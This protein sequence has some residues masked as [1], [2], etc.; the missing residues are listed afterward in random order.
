MLNT[1]L[2]RKTSLI[3]LGILALTVALMLSYVA[4]KAD[5]TRSA[6]RQIDQ[7]RALFNQTSSELAGSAAAIDPS[8]TPSPAVLGADVTPTPT[9]TPDPTPTPSDTPQASPD[10]SPSPSPIFK[11]IYGGVGVAN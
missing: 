8:P 3:A 11:P 5:Q 2:N 10:P 4:I 7:S 1:T 6:L 9:V